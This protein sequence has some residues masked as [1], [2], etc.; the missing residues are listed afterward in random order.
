MK[1]LAVALA[2]G[3]ALTLGGLQ[4]AA[5]SADAGPTCARRAG[6]QTTLIIDGGLYALVRSST[7]PAGYL[8]G[9]SG[10]AVTTLQPALRV[11]RAFGLS[12]QRLAHVPPVRGGTYGQG[13]GIGYFDF[14]CRGTYRVIALVRK[15]GPTR[16]WLQEQH[17]LQQT[18]LR[19]F[20]MR[21]LTLR[22]GALLAATFRMPLP[23]AAPRYSV[24]RD[25]DGKTD[26]SGRFR[27]GG[28]R[29]PRHSPARCARA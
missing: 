20:C 24:D 9:W 22:R 4:R 19:A 23:A 5:R 14:R 15:A 2:A 29:F 8:G 12:P 25:G 11:A 28:A 10:T 16:F 7:K 13:G 26:A 18:V 27:P 17:G 6:E 21:P 3:L 1:L